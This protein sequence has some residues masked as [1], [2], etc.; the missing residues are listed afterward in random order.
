MASTLGKEWLEKT[1]TSD[2]ALSSFAFIN[3]RKKEMKESENNACFYPLLHE[4]FSG[5]NEFVYKHRE[6]YQA[7]EYADYLCRHSIFAKGFITK[8]GRELVDLGGRMNTKYHASYHIAGAI[9]DRLRVEYSQI[10]MNWEE[11]VK[12]GVGKH[13]ALLLSHVF[14]ATPKSFILCLHGNGHKVLNA[15]AMGKENLKAFLTKAPLEFRSKHSL[16]ECQDY[17]GMSEMWGNLMGNP[18]RWQEHIPVI[19]ETGVFGKI[20]LYQIR[21]KDFLKWWRKTK[22]EIL[23]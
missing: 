12:V 20:H 16:K 1:Q 4:S 22:K 6:G 9:F 23:S 11:L 18:F 19:D 8:S 2:L 10:V 3:T 15:S 13:D 17:S 14:K 21:K 7:Y 5:S